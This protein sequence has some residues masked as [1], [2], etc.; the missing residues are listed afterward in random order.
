MMLGGF[1][2]G[3]VAGLRC[4]K[5]I[6]SDTLTGTWGSGEG[7]G[8]VIYFFLWRDN[9]LEAPEMSF[10]RGGVGGGIVKGSMFILLQSQSHAGPECHSGV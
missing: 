1:K 7:K 3:G 10:G 9:C 6:V 5:R 8:G 4:Q 2:G